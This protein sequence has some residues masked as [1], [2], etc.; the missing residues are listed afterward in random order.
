MLIGPVDEPACERAG[1]HSTTCAA[2]ADGIEPHSAKRG[3]PGG[4][5]SR[6]QVRRRL[7]PLPLARAALAIAAPAQ[8]LQQAARKPSH[9]MVAIG[10]LYEPTDRPAALL[11]G[12]YDEAIPYYTDLPRCECPRPWRCP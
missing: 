1:A 6:A 8:N 11:V 9:A 7:S 4:S 2:S 10:A 5:L 3:R 12:D